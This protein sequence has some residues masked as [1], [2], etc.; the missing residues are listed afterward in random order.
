LNALISADL[1][2]EHGSVV[3]VRDR[4]VQEEARVAD[5]F[6]GYQDALG[7]HPL[8]NIFESLPFLVF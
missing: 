3:G 2:V 6:R 4:L 5:A 7:I 1:S 8:Q